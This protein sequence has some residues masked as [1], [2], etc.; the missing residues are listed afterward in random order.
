MLRVSCLD[1]VGSAQDRPTLRARSGDT[2]REPRSVPDVGLTGV[3]FGVIAAAW[4]VYLVP[5]FLRRQADPALDEADPAEPFSA[6]VTIVRRG[7]SLAT[8]E[9]GAAVVST[10]LTRRAA[11]YELAQIDRQAA[12][13]RRRVLVFLTLA[14]LAVSV[15]AALSLLAWWAPI[16]PAG[17]LLLFLVVARFSVQAMRRDL[18]A[19]A[20]R[21]R[22]ASDEQTVAIAVL[23]E[24]EGAAEASIELSAPISRP[25]SLWDPIPITA[26]T[27]VSKP[28]APRTVRTI[29]LSA[30]VAPASAVPVTAE[31][32]PEQ[33][34]DDGDER[35]AVGE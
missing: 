29:D 18:D 10:P 13:R 24:D 6:T 14:L 25:G 35:R 31:P 8:A 1:A 26:P 21:I 19:R 7:V 22:E 23:S 17:L 4:L 27:Y 30:P 9:E 15:P 2:P 20:Q 34:A 32:L 16:V 28:L 3:I 12:T 11:L 5:Y 33:I